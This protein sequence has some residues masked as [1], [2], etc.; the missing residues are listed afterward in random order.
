MLNLIE[1][2]YGSKKT[3]IMGDWSVGK[4]MANFISTPNLTLKRQ[5]TRRF[6]VLDIDKIDNFLE[7]DL[8]ITKKS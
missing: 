4:Q 5:L 7:L 1:K 3:I 6:K 2:T 8:K